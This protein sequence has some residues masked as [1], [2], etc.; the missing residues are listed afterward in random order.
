[1]TKLHTLKHYLLIGPN[2]AGKTVHGRALAGLTNGPYADMSRILNIASAFQSEFRD[3]IAD[4]QSRGQLVPDEITMPAFDTYLST[5]KRGTSLVFMGV[6]RKES[7][8]DPFI[9]S[10]ERHIGF[11]QLIVA[12]LQLLPETAIARCKQRADDDRRA[13]RTPRADDEDE[14]LISKRLTDWDKERGRFVAKLQEYA[15]DRKSVV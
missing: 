8:V 10:L 14:A 5:H 2:G 9:E 7:Q 4:Y 13:G 1:M 12:D 11:S 6:P 3:T 15:T